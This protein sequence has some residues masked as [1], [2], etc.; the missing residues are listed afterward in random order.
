RRSKYVSMIANFEHW[1]DGSLSGLQIAPASPADGLLVA[2]SESSAVCY[3][4][5]MD[6]GCDG[7][8]VPWEDATNLLVHGDDETKLLV[9]TAGDLACFWNGEIEDASFLMRR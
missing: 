3:V 7:T 6:P 9:A 4:L 5:A 1:V 8:F 2:L